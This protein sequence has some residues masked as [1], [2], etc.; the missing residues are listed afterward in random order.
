MITCESLDRDFLARFTDGAHEAL[1]DTTPQWGG[2]SAGF[3]P[4]DLIEAALASCITIVT[5]MSAKK[6]DIPLEAMSVTVTLNRD[7]P[8]KAT[9]TYSMDLK[10][11]LT[12]E[13]RDKLKRAA[14]ACPVHK[15]L[16]RQMEFILAE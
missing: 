14:K 8:A 11:D 9:F 6:H 13:Q 7:D 12:P 3:A 10:G 1:A 15:T 2:A 4:H 5:R 16:C